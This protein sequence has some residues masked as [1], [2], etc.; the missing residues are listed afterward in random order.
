M[1]S[2][3][4]KTVWITGASSGIGEALAYE[5]ARS[6]AKLILSSRRSAELER[7]RAACMHAEKH[8]IVP[9]DLE[10]YLEVEERIA[11]IIEAHEPIDILINNAGISHRFEVSESNILLDKKIM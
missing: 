7:V 1:D 8:I 5:L 3:E 4:N 9:L 6:G 2:M 10:K 11:S